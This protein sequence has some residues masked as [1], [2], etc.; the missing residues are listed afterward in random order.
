MDI[1]S[2]TKG[3]PKVYFKANTN[4][5]ILKDIHTKHKP[6]SFKGCAFED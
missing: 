5:R 3:Q 4:H 1:P 6:R 2:K